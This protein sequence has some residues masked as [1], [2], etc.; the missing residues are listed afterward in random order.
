MCEGEPVT[1]RGNVF[2][3]EDLPLGDVDARQFLFLCL[4]TYSGLNIFAFID[5]WF[6]QVGDRTGWSS[7]SAIQVQV[8]STRAVN[9][10][11]HV[12]TVLMLKIRLDVDIGTS[13]KWN[14]CC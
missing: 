12:C 4:K 5:I 9:I 6:L 7:A 3:E 10:E 13:Y 1:C 8:G 14:H 11:Q 2:Q